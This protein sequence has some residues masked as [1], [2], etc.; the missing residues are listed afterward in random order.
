MS[1]HDHVDAQVRLVSV[2]LGQ[3]ELVDGA[4]QALF[5]RA[6]REPGR[7]LAPDR[8]QPLGQVEAQGLAR[9]GFD[10][11]AVR[12][13]FELQQKIRRFDGRLEIG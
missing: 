2:K 1:G 6:E 7:Q 9:F 10:A 11:L 3:L 8:T 5:G 12:Q 4:G 13:G